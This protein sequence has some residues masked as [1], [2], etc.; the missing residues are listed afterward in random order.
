MSK[1]NGPAPPDIAPPRTTLPPA[2]P[3]VEPAMTAERRDPVVTGER[4]DPGFGNQLGDQ[5]AFAP[6]APGADDGLTIEPHRT[7]PHAAP[8]PAQAGAAKQDRARSKSRPKRSGLHLVSRLFSAAVIL[9]FFAMGIWWVIASGAFQSAAQRDTSVPNPPPTVNEEDF[10]AAAPRQLNP[11]AGFTGEWKT[12][13]TPTQQDGEIITSARAQAE[14]AGSGENRVLRIV[15]TAGDGSGEVR[16][17]ID[18]AVLG[19]AAQ[20]QSIVALT[21][22]SVGEEPTQIYVRCDIPGLGD[23]GRRR[24]DVG[25][26]IIDVLFDLEFDGASTPSGPGHIV[27][28]SD[29]AGTGRGVELHAIR[30]RPAS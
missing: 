13:F 4:R 25:T 5:P 10:D 2:A 6:T 1:P 7:E 27:I 3:V 26:A 18:S 19:D 9:S 29:I 15:S 23:C 12:A 28:N 24:F 16:I 8:L 30:I 21:V 17:P 14:F 11:G 22:K 20:R